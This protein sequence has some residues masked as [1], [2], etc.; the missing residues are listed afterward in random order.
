MHTVVGAACVPSVLRGDKSKNQKPG[1]RT[2]TWL[3]DRARV[4]ILKLLCDLPV[5]HTSIS[6]GEMSMVQTGD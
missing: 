3:K 5:S 2:T 1:E 6:V 4:R